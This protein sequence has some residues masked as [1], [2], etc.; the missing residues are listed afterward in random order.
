MNI[1]QKSGSYHLRY[2]SVESD[3]NDKVIVDYGSYP[4]RDSVIFK[5]KYGVKLK[6]VDGN[7]LTFTGVSQSDTNYI[8][9][10]RGDKKIG[11]LF[12][13][14]YKPQTKYIELVSV[15]R[16][17]IDKS[18]TAEGL[19]KLFKG[20]VVNF[21]IE[22]KS[23]DIRDLKTFTHG[24]SN[25]HS[26]YNDDQKKVLEAYDSQMKDDKFYLFF[27]DNVLNKKDS[28]GTSV[29][30]YMPRGYNAGFIYE[31]GSLHTV[32]H[33]LGHGIGNLEHVFENSSNSGKT[34]NLMDYSFEKDAEQLWHFQWDQIQDPSRVWMKWNKDE[35]EGENIEVLD[36]DA[37][38]VIYIF[39]PFISQKIMANLDEDFMSNPEKVMRVKELI[40]LACSQD[41]GQKV[42]NNLL[43]ELKNYDFPN[44]G[45]LK[46]KLE[47][48]NKYASFRI[49]HQVRNNNC[50]LYL[51]HGDADIDDSENFTRIDTPYVFKRVELIVPN[52]VDKIS[53]FDASQYPGKWVPVPTKPKPKRYMDKELL[54]YHMYYKFDDPTYQYYYTLLMLKGGVKLLV[55]REYKY[56]EFVSYKIQFPNENIW[57]DLP[58][59]NIKEN[60]LSCELKELGGQMINIA[61]K[62]GVPVAGIVA[63]VTTI[64]VVVASGGTAGPVAF[65]VADAIKTAFMIMSATYSIASNSARLIITLT[66]KDKNNLA[67]KIPGGVLNATIGLI[68]LHTSDN[69]IV[70]SSVPVVLQLSEGLL[71]LTWKSPAKITSL[72]NTDNILN[73]ICT[74]YYGNAKEL[75]DIFVNNHLKN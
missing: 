74:D 42:K 57:Y 47:R 7:I 36:K 37:K 39:S 15:N 9:A 22:I 60:C 33:E 43:K 48:A 65:P 17:K 3:K 11:K 55:E 16:A 38:Y 20:A 71:T 75:W 12:L 63:G 19:N 58:L 68:V 59:E 10:Y 28:L 6:V 25:W 72:E 4:D 21:K 44:I 8:Y 50:I 61:V 23:L 45:A 5:D 51:L 18:I 53:R 40:R 35:S 1:I 46:T 32:A 41:L 34:K 29:S 66:D 30:G 14:T 56:E 26:V 24:G 27:V 54:T 52:Y 13:N 64:A 2:K 73:V 31:G 69:E 67:D 62:Y 49:N 70:K